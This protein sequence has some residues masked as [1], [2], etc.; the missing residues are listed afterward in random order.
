MLTPAV[1]A[2][3]EAAP[4]WFFDEG[5]GYDVFGLRPRSVQRA[6][7]WGRPVFE[8]YFRVQS[9]GIEHVPASGPAILVA[10]HGGTLPIDGAMLWFDIAFRTQRILRLIAD[11]FVP[12]LPIVSTLFARTG[13]VSGSAANVRCLLERGEL[14]GIFPEGTTGPAKP[15]RER[16]QLQQW[17]VGHAE[18][19]LR[20]RAPIIPVAIVG[21]EESWPVLLRLPWLHAFGAPYLPVPMSPLPLPVPISIH[22]GAPIELYRRYGAELADDPEALTAAAGE[23]RVSLATLLERALHERDERAA[24]APWSG[25]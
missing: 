10:N 5:H 17:R 13:T 1:E 12:H 14:L 22:Y 11:F 16:Y 25:A 6:L 8:R 23:V 18:H 20:H 3:R 2:S 19:A 9:H 4:P 7:R 24:R 15:R 21:A